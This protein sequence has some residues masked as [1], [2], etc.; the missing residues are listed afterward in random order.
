MNIKP[1]MQFSSWDSLLYL[2]VGIMLISFA[3]RDIIKKKSFIFGVEFYFDQQ[4]F[5]YSFSIFVK[6]AF[7]FVTFIYAIG[8]LL[9]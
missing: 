1:F 5:A 8:K 2:S 6:L 7:G 9:S 4:P 3:I